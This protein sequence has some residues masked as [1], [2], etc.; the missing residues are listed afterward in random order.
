ME[1]MIHNNVY[2]Y[3]IGKRIATNETIDFMM[4]IPLAVGQGGRFFFVN[5]G[6][7]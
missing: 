4:R 6:L 2:Q 3:K 5:A 7:N 1:V